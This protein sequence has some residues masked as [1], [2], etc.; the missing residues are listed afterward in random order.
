[1]WMDILSVP[2]WKHMDGSRP[3]SPG[4]EWPRAVPGVVQ[5]ASPGHYPWLWW[6]P[7]FRLWFRLSM[8]SVYVCFPRPTEPS[9]DKLCVFRCHVGQ[10]LSNPGDS[11]TCLCLPQTVP[12]LSVS[13]GPESGFPFPSPSISQ[14]LPGP[15]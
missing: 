12:L 6:S 10:G 9:E 5:V 1:M 15:R 7:G 8:G 13:L 4:R 2:H 11:Q 3:G 14:R